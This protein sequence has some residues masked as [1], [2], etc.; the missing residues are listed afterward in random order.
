M[1]FPFNMIN[2]LLFFRY[3][4]SNVAATRICQNAKMDHPIH[5]IFLSTLTR[6]L[7]YGAN[8]FRIV[9]HPGA[10]GKTSIF[11]ILQYF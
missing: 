10:G 11:V 3:I 7:R 9:V 1:I 5:Y 4:N 6:S 8:L 2:L